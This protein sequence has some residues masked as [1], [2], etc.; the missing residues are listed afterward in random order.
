MRTMEFTIENKDA[1]TIG[2]EM[3]VTEG[4]LPS[5]YYYTLEHALGMS[6]NFRSFERLKSTKAV[7]YTH[8]SV[9][10]FYISDILYTGSRK[11]RKT[12]VGVC[13]LLPVVHSVY[14][15]KYSA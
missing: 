1:F 10:G 15:C 9:C 8:L 13:D 7:S 3:S 14:C 6:G 12:C 4:V 2:Q 5:S 11:Q